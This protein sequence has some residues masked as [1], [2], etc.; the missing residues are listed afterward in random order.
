VARGEVIVVARFQEKLEYLNQI[1]IALSSERDIDVL[2]EKIMI[3]AK[4]LS[5]ADGGTVYLMNEANE[6][7]CFAFMRSDSLNITYGGKG[8]EPPPFPDLPLYR[9]DGS[10]NRCTVAVYAA[11]TGKTVNIADAYD[12]PGFDFSGTRAIDQTTGGRSKSFLTVPL[13]NHEDRV[14]GVLQLL[15]AMDPDTQVV[16]P[17]SED[18]E[19][20][21]NSLGSQAAVAL[22]NK[23]LIQQLA[24][25]FEAFIAMINTAIDEKSP[26][27]GHHCNMVPELT[28]MIAEALHEADYGALADFQLT[29]ADRYELRIAGLLHDCGKITT[30]VHVFDKATKLQTLYDRI[31]LVDTRFEVVRR[32]ARIHCLEAIAAG[33]PAEQAEAGL[34]ATLARIDDDQAFLHRANVGSER[35]QQE[36]QNRVFAIARAYLWQPQGCSKAQ[37]F[38]SAD[39]IENLCIIAGTL[40]KD[41]REI[42]NN[43]IVTTNRMLEALPWPRHLRRVPEYAGGHHERMDGKGYPRGLTRDE[44]SVQARL[45]GI[46]DIFEALTARDRPYK[47]PMSLSVA[48]GILAR[49]SANGHVDPDI[50]EVFTRSGV[51]RRYGEQFLNPDQIDQ[52]D[53]E[54]ILE[55]ARPQH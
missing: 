28:M 14:V 54:Q 53:I 41:E 29:E 45:M 7:L 49:F 44:M 17:F 13:K 15:N 3:A 52:V 47:K 40:T 39:E 1:G 42:I 43:H 35:M 18:I 26:H 38:L 19:R 48:M 4:T 9:P 23:W 32:D 51:W 30:P 12:E 2:L 25:L 22:T 55:Q 46:S 50:F 5:H 8:Q 33:T 37:D 6:S 16:I 11:L 21:V 20:L 10:E 31:D 24:E 34:A 36:D 27:T